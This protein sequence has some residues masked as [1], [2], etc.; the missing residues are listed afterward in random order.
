VWVRD[1]ETSSGTPTNDYFY[2]RCRSKYNVKSGCANGRGVRADALERVAWEAVSSALLHPDRLRAGLEKMIESR[3]ESLATKPD[4]QIARWAA[5]VQEAKAKRARYQDQEAEGL[6]TREELRT[7][8]S[9]L[10]ETM[11]LA[12]AEID[13]LRGHEEAFRE[14]Q[15]GGEELLERYARL[16][17]QGCQ[18]SCDSCL[19]MVVFEMLRSRFGGKNRQKIGT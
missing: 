7:K 14:L 3:R 15:R 12:E 17:F 2:Y 10:D 5:E 6:M 18:G 11:E 19:P 16:V 9:K 13:N 1:G 4:E 8:L